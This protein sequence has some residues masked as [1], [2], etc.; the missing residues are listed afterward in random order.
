MKNIFYL[1]T[2]LTFVFII[3]AVD[4]VTVHNKTEDTLYAAVYYYPSSHTLTKRKAEK[5]GNIVTLNASQN[6]LLSR[7]NRKNGY[8]RD[9]LFSTNRKSLK[10]QLTREEFKILPKFNIGTLEGNEFYITKEDGVYKNYTALNWKYIKPATKKASEISDTLSEAALKQMRKLFE[11]H[12]YGQRVAHVRTGTDLSQE[13][14]NYLEMRKPK[15]KAALEKLT[16]LKLA[17][18][19]VLRIA[20]SGSG[21][22]YRAM[23]STLGSVIGAHE[24]GLLDAITY[25]SALSGSTWMLA[26]W[27]IMG[28]TPAQ[29]REQL[30]PR[31]SEALFPQWTKLKTAEIAEQALKKFVFG[32]PVS[33][34]DLY[35]ALLGR[36]LLGNGV[37][38]YAIT[39]GSQ[40]SRIAHGDWV[41]PIY[42]AVVTKT[43]PYQWVEFTPYEIG[44]DYLGGYVPSWALGRK[45]SQGKSTTFS[46]PQPLGFYMGIWGSAFSANFKEI[47]QNTIDQISP[48]QLRDAL[49]YGTEELKVGNT[50]LLPAKVFNYTRGIP[51]L[52]RNQEETLTLIDA[53]LSCNLP[54]VPLLKKERSVDVLVFLDASQFVDGAT[55]L[56]CVEAYA[57]KNN[58]KFPVI[59]YKD[60]GK[61][62]VSIFK[63]EKDPS[64]PVVIYLPRIKN[65]KYSKTFD[66]SENIAKGGYARTDNFAYTPE[67]VRQLSGLTE[68][69]MKES[70]DA[71]INAL[72]DAIL[73]RRD[74]KNK[75]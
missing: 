35:G 50:R 58:I 64:V 18:D 44:S 48:K 74:V 27:T 23:V 4:N 5:V 41:F 73:A 1:I 46:P 33:L 57:R 54:G 25:F 22:G 70:K 37:N 56:K 10:D 38:P 67:E 2:S 20:F 65:D 34:I 19:E 52:P 75:K 71:I 55:E 62:T 60:I 40:I 45:F 15:V 14:K 51:G 36:R 11:S 13:E 12:E 6:A 16:G 39:L 30:I 42:T 53:G 47:Y 21:G 29:F 68:F 61:K 72:R 3:Q 32:E 66:P 49:Q 24:T 8:D 69:N 9:V 26:P 63:D 7:P 28:I 43:E 59:N 17:D 31:I